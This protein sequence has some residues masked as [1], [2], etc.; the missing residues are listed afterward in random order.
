MELIPCEMTEELPAR[1]IG[2]YR[3]GRLHVFRQRFLKTGE[4]IIPSMIRE[5]GMEEVRQEF[6][7]FLRLPDSELETYVPFSNTKK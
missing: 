4:I 5:E 2:P 1:K 6:E 3:L 7:R